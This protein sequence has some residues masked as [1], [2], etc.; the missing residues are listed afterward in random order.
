M[1][2]KFWKAT[3]GGET[4]V[5]RIVSDDTGRGSKGERWDGEK[6]VPSDSVFDAVLGTGSW[7]LYDE[8]TEA[9]AEA[10]MRG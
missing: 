10:V 4:R 1:P 6:W 9:E 7:H 3:R 5:Y 8:I 2:E